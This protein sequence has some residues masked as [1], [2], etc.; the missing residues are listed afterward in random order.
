MAWWVWIVGGVLLCLAE[1]AT[2][3]AFYLLF[4]GVAA[5][6]VGVL[7]WV[8]LVETTW[9]QFL[10]FSV[11][12]IASLV[13]FRRMLTEKLNPDEPAT[14]INTL[15]GESATAL[16]DIPA[17]GTGKV[18]VRGTN[19]N[20]VNKGDTLIEKGQACVVERVEGVSLWVR[21]A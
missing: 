11:V 8:G 5:L 6:V 18:E 10:L 13:L 20:A 15:E 19:W 14:K 2:P 9:V 7:A 17:Q 1:M 4:F 21:S 12:S 16:E 3:G